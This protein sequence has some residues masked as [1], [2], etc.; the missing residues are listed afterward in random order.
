MVNPSITM[1]K[2]TLQGEQAMDYVRTRKGVGDQLNLS[3]MERQEQ[4]M[5]SLLAALKAQIADNDKFILNLYEQIAPYMVTDCSVNSFSN[6]MERSTDYNLS[7]IVSPEG[8]NVLGKEN[9]EFYADEEK[10]DQLILR[11]FYRAK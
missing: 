11:M 1:G 4:Y 6:L 9:Y 3:R 5:E 8:K 10:L 2:V 7:E